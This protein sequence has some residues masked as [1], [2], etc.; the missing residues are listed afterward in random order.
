MGLLKTGSKCVA[1]E[2]GAT[3]RPLAG[4]WTD[5]LKNPTGQELGNQVKRRLSTEEN[6]PSWTFAGAELKLLL[7]IPHS[8]TVSSG[9]ENVAGQP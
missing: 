8:L 7:P 1:P 2:N 6:L 3:A 9:S 5:S 4:Q